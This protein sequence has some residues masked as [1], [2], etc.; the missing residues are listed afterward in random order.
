[1]KKSLFLIVLALVSITFANAQNFS[2]GARL[3]L[4]D[5]NQSFSASGAS[6]SPSSKIGYLI[7]GY[8]KFM[9]NDNIGLQ[10]ELLFSSVGSKWP[11]SLTGGSEAT[12]RMNY[13][14]IPVLFRY[15]ITENFHLLAG[16]QLGLLMSAKG[17]S[18]GTT[19]DIKS[20]FNSS[21]F[22]AVIGA[23]VDFGP[24][25]A[26]LRYCAGLTNIANSSSFGGS[27]VTVKNT[28]LQLVVGYKLFG[29]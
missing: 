17:I 9:F 21:D 8:A 13:I 20:D 29:K 19:T 26:G 25:N 2:I 27:S 5:A 10:P 11:A 28:A 18:G 12:I 7:G 14:S 6:V 16:P 4:N 1:M 3:G 24:F 22:S 15:N 23:G